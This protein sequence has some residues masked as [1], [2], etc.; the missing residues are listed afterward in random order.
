MSTP[1]LVVTGYLGAG[2]STL[3]NT[4][5]SEAGGRR[6]AAIINDFGAINIDKELI[7]T[8]GDSVVGLANGC[9]CCTLQGD[10]LRTLKLLLARDP[11]PD[12]IVI[13]ASGVADPAGILQALADPVLWKS[14]R[15]DAVVCVVD[16][17][18]IIAMPARRDDS[19][20][21]AQLAAASFILLSKTA[22]MDD[23][24]LKALAAS[25]SPD[26]KPPVIDAERERLPV[27]LLLDSG[28][29][30]LR[31]S[32][33]ETGA[34]HRQDRFAKLEW[35]SRGAISLAA[36]Q[37]V[38]ADFAPSLVR[39]K[40]ILRFTGKPGRPYLLQLVGRR[41]TLEPLAGEYEHGC[42]LVLIGEA[43]RLDRSALEACLDQ[44]EQR[45]DDD[46]TAARTTGFAS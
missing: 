12:H 31:F 3:I 20:W 14:V 35:Q 5:L 26:A 43:A 18:D 38:I 27:E 22:R 13:E 7:R 44:L 9:V 1:V 11:A 30:S 6:I 29:P 23:G 45:S 46:Q 24:Q 8:A 21:R 28:K 32:A 36:L 4:L 33:T 16:A 10:L 15:P 25:L 37:A 17:E 34:P 40:G 41:V 2:K 39:G 42:R 19:L